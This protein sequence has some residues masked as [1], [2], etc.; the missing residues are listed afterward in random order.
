MDQITAFFQYL[1]NSEEIIQTGGLIA[2]VLIVYIENGIFFGFFLPGDYLLFLSGVFSGL[3]ILKVSLSILLL[4][5]FA[6]AI[7]GSFTGY[8]FGFY[9]GGALE[10][11]KE[12]LFFKRKY[13]SKTK[14]YFEK[15]GSRTLIIARFLPVIRT[16]APIM[17][18]LVK[19]NFVNFSL[20]NIMGAAFWAG[21]LVTSGYFLG[22]KFPWII[23]YVHWII[24][25]FLVVTSFTVVKGYFSAKN[26]MDQES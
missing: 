11:R 18:G 14:S 21:S 23:D 1:M 26:E 9:F 7:A 15:Y 4:A 6:A 17:A 24:L 10:N 3:G 8:L 19:M 20:Y 22:E 12:N 16:F 5:I 2:I 25:F 13:I